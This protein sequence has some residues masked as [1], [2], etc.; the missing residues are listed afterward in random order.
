MPVALSGPL[1]SVAFLV[2][3]VVRVS[4]HRRRP[5]FVAL[6]CNLT[7]IP[8]ASLRADKSRRGAK[9]PRP[10]FQTGRAW[11]LADERAAIRAG[12]GH[13]RRQLSPH[14]EVGAR[15]RRGSL[16]ATGEDATVVLFT[17]AIKERFLLRPALTLCHDTTQSAHELG[18]LIGVAPRPGDERPRSDRRARPVA[19]AA[20][21]SS[22]TRERSMIGR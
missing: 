15:T 19:P 8:R 10:R 4:C 12:C 18:R 1:G 14:K 16:Y 3:D 6:R 22:W 9:E 20:T 21:A 2:G 17:P 5:V 11:Q 13:R 7:R